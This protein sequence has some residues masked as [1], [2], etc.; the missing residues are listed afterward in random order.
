M[1]F[2]Y[3]FKN[4]FPQ[5]EDDK[6]LKLVQK[7]FC[8]SGPYTGKRR[9][10]NKNG[11]G[12]EPQNNPIFKGYCW[13]LSFFIRKQQFW[14]AE[15]AP[16]LC[17]A[18]IQVRRS[19]VGPVPLVVSISWHHSWAQ[20]SFRNINSKARALKERLGSS[21]FMVVLV[22][23]MADSGADSTHL[24]CLPKLKLLA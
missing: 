22:G 6:V 17:C 19:E 11:A 20:N 13:V 18:W 15:T 24:P 7:K 16:G 5:Q 12:K 14:G 8:A 2:F 21:C 10:G 23:A 4:F 9:A 3:L 1:P